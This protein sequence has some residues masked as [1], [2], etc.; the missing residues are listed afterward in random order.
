VIQHQSKSILADEKRQKYV[1]PTLRKSRREKEQEA[2]EAK[3]RDAEAETA[4]AYEEF[5]NVFEG[6]GDKPS[7]TSFVKAE[8]KAA[9]AP[10]GMKAR[11]E[12]ERSNSSRVCAVSFDVIRNNICVLML[13]IR[14][15]YPLL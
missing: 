5:V 3:A 6:S 4:R 1:Q 15:H 11:F 14:D 10:V 7:R 12:E 2:A 9:Y 8:S 13:S